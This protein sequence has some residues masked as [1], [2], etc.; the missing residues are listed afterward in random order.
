MKAL[1]VVTETAPQLLD[2]IVVSIG[3][4]GRSAS[5]FAFERGMASNEMLDCNL[6]KLPP[7]IQLCFDLSR[8]EV[9]QC[10]VYFENPFSD[11]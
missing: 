10:P 1:V 11:R 5:V 3:N 6:A 2:S 9:T 7:F 4:F 8:L